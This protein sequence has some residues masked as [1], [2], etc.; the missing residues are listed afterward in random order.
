MSLYSINYKHIGSTLVVTGRS[1]VL[2]RDT[3][4]AFLALLRTLLRIWGG[5]GGELECLG[6]KLPPV[7]RTLL[8][9]RMFLH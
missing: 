4:L 1:H 5:G 3:E 6:E 8:S 2:A 7:D 9:V